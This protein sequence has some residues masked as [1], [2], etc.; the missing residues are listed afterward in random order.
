MHLFK[1][2]AAGIM[3]MT[4]ALNDPEILHGVTHF[5]T[6]SYRTIRFHIS[7]NTKNHRRAK[8]HK[9]NIISNRVDDNSVLRSWKERRAPPVTANIVKI[10]H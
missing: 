8:K 2:Q 6:V 9:I 7:M 5:Q 3:K 4:H 1:P 10:P